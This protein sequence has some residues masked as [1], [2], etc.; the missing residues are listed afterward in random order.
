VARAYLG[1]MKKLFFLLLL[2]FAALHVSAQ[3][4]TPVKLGLKLPK[5]Q[6]CTPVKDQANSST[7]WSFASNSFLESEVKR[8]GH[9]EIDMSEMFVARYSYIRK[10]ETH[11]RQKGKNFFTPGGQFHDVLWVMKNH[12]MVPQAAYPGITINGSFYDHSELD[13]AIKQYVDALLANNIT[14]LQEPHY[15]YIDSVLDKYLGIVPADFN[16][17]NQSYTP[18]SF[19]AK[20]TGINA[21][22]YVEITSYTHHPFYTKYILEDKYN[23]T[24]D[25]YYNV[26][27]PDFS[28]ITDNALRNGFTVCWDGDVTENSFDFYGGLAWLD[29]KGSNFQAERQRT[30]LDGSTG[31]DHVMHITAPVKDNRGGKW[32][33]VKNSWG[34]T[35]NQL[36]GFMFMSDAY[37]KIK[38]T[39]IIVHKDAI[40]AAIRKKMGL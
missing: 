5:L 29:F 24:G 14:A 6:N 17:K 25:Q 21:D 36:G 27:M 19:A 3:L 16:Y 9:K 30:L 22:D 37:F 35:G 31:I 4:Y 12:G 39:A 13:T 10:I 8:L 20:V 33:C 26:P 2:A 11:I 28:A 38:T 18:Q 15:R 34:S 32:Y 7:C 40:P 1:S 23:W